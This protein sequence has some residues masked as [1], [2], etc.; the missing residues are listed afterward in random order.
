MQLFII[1]KL[2]RVFSKIKKDLVLCI[3]PQQ[4]PLETLGGALEILNCF[5]GHTPLYLLIN[6]CIS[7]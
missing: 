3:C 6:I 4:L 2:L 5:H 7:F 1:V